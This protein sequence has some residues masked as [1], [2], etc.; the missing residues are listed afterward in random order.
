MAGGTKQ[1]GEGLGA[2]RDAAPQTGH[3]HPRR[4]AGRGG[5]R[6]APSRRSPSSAE[7]LS[8]HRVAVAGRAPAAS[9]HPGPTRGGTRGT[10]RPA[11]APPA[12]LPRAGGGG[13]GD[14]TRDQPPMEDEGAASPAQSRIPPAAEEGRRARRGREVFPRDKAQVALA[15]RTG[16]SFSKPLQTAAPLAHGCSVGHRRSW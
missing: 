1:P 15:S 10:A 16:S 7:G 13:G 9:A 8:Y 2:E 11:P 3:H 5:A 14:D 4:G 12:S 6:P